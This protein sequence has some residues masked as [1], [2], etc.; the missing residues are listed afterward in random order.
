MTLVY[1]YKVLFNLLG[2]NRVVY[3]DKLKRKEIMYILGSGPSMNESLKRLT[4]EKNEKYEYFALN[5]FSVSD[6]FTICKPVYYIMLDPCYWT[7][8]D[9]TNEN[10]FNQ[11]LK[12]FKSLEELTNW[13]MTVFIPSDVYKKLF[14]QKAIKNT[15]IIFR[16]FNY[17]NFYPTQT[18]YYNWVLKHN[19]GVVPV[20][21]VLGGAIYLSI[22]LGYK[23]IRIIGAEHSW[24]EDIRV[25]DQNQVCTIKKHFYG[26]G[27]LEPWLKSN[28]EPFKMY[29]ILSSLTNHFKGYVFLNWYAEKI[30]ATVLNCTKGSFI[31]AF[32]RA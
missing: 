3:N 31:D 4:C 9:K 16:P 11:R 6:Y 28:K 27:T 26:E 12:T 22:N 10:D 5:D 24:T 2:N 7:S 32:K 23:E 8:Q 30:G 29:E 17:S 13:D 19:F 20:G 18:Y 15:H 25:N 14:L 21:N 1:S